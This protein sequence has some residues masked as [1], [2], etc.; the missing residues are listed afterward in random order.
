MGVAGH[1]HILILITL[2]DELVE[3]YLY[4]ISDI[5]QLVANGQETL[6]CSQQDIKRLFQGGK[7]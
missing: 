5:L 2:G 4:L 7:L 1:Q 6:N 3:E